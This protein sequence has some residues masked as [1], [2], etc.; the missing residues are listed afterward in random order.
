MRICI[1]LPAA[2]RMACAVDVRQVEL[3]AAALAPL[4]VSA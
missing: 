1:G 2:V 4:R 3:L